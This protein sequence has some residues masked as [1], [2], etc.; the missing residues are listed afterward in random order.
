[1][2]LSKCDALDNETIEERLAAL[3]KAARKKP[4]VLSA[5]S[6]QGMKDALYALG[7]EI[8]RAGTKDDEELQTEHKPWRP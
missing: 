1:V 2:A 5:V 8:G 7:R 3:Q 4:L 6:G